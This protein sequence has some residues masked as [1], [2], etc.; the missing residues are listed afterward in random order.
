MENPKVTNI[1]KNRNPPAV[2]VININFQLNPPKNIKP[3]N[4]IGIAK[5]GKRYERHK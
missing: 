1:D 5:K 3:T 2:V 4:P